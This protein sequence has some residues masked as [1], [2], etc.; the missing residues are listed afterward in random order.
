M[1]LILIDEEFTMPGSQI[2]QSE[3]RRKR[4]ALTPIY[5]LIVVLCLYVVA[6]ALESPVIALINKLKP[7]LNFQLKPPDISFSPFTMPSSD[8]LLFAI[9]IW[10]VFLALAYFLVAILSGR[11]PNTGKD[12]IMPP[13]TKEEKR[14]RYGGG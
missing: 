7:G 8:H 4:S 2:V 11:S 1:I 13:R 12:I 14:R 10:I 3:K 9:P 6:Y 5:G